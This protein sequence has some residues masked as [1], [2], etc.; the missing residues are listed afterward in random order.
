M[1]TERCPEFLKCNYKLPSLFTYH[2]ALIKSTN[3]EALEYAKNCS[4]WW[5]YSCYQNQVSSLI[6]FIVFFS[7]ISYRSCFNALLWHMTFIQ[8]WLKD[9]DI[10]NRCISL[11]GLYIKHV[12]KNNLTSG[13]Q[14]FENFSLACVQERVTWKNLVHACHSLLMSHSLHVWDNNGLESGSVCHRNK[15]S[16]IDSQ[17]LEG[18]FQVICWH[19][20]SAVTDDSMTS[21]WQTFSFPSWNL[22]S[23][24]WRGVTLL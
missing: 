19:S 13:Y 22:R 11:Y 20:C 15:D 21:H 18:D 8:L 23:A 5:G 17:V 10:T 9:R 1:G 6:E 3:I 16:N 14:L 4:R 12:V 24:W 7:E 2:R